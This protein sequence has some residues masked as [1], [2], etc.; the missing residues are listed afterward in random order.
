M[1]KFLLFLAIIILF[2]CT[3]GPQ[4]VLI[5]SFEGEI[6][7]KTVDFGSAEGSSLKVTADK[8]K[9]ACGEQA[10]KIEYD[11]KPSGYMWIARGYNLDVKGANKW[12]LKPQDIK[13][14][15]YE[16]ISVQMYG[17]NKGGVVAFDIKDKGQEVWR[18]LLDDD[19]TGWK[20]IACSL[21]EF[22]PRKDWQP[23]TAERNEVLDFP[24]MSF[25]FEPRLPGKGTYYFDC[26]KLVK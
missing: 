11:L 17:T 12:L 9:K 26:L 20:E 8:N 25:Q 7:S 6:N 4:E 1:K 13:W 21:K 2:G 24:I 16:A 19:F 3:Q 18:F 23:E 15:K 22:F 10:L 5:D 14:R